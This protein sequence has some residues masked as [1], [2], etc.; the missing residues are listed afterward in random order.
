[1]VYKRGRGGLLG[2]VDAGRYA[3][4]SK[5]RKWYALVVSAEDKY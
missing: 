1:M 2:A 5:D 4:Y 3:C